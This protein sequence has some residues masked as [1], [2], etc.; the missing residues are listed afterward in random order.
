MMDDKII[1]YYLVVHLKASSQALR[2]GPKFE[3]TALLSLVILP[4]LPELG[5]RFLFLRL[6]VRRNLF[7]H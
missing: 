6:P 1:F 2:T 3:L 4:R 7:E 5:E